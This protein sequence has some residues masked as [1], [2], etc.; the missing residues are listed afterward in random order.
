MAS[1]M[2]AGAVAFAALNFPDETVQERKARILDTV[3]PL[4][5]LTDRVLTGGS[6]NLRNIV[7]TDGDNLPDWW[8]Q[9]AFE[10]L[11][12]TASQDNDNDGDNNREEFLAQTDP[13]DPN[14]RLQDAD[15]SKISDF[16]MTENGELEF[17]FIAYPDIRYSIESIDGLSGS[18]WINELSNLNGDG[19]LQKV[20]ID[21]LDVQESQ[22]YRIRSS[23]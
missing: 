10:S 14:S 12:Y 18:T 13:T 15:Y 7:D 21:E 5:S 23:K 16:S 3:V 20:T 17:T 22:F 11:I 2:V 8:E 1:P 6:L 9:D 4:P 19:T